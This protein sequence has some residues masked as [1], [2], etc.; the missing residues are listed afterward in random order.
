MVLVVFSTKDAA[1]NGAWYRYQRFVI[2][3]I[4]NGSVQY[5]TLM[6]FVVLVELRTLVS[7]VSSRV[8]FGNR[9]RIFSKVETR[10]THFDTCGSQ[11]HSN[12]HSVFLRNFRAED[13][14]FSIIFPK[15]VR[16]FFFSRTAE[17]SNDV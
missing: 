17:N 11:K 13:E 7:Y 1:H 10:G 15:R 4:E 6:A 12:S 9:I 14:L 2:F 16:I 5:V 3:S 8:S